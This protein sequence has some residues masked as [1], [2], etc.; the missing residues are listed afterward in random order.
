MKQRIDTAL[1]NDDIH[2]RWRTMHTLGLPKRFPQ[3]QNM[4]DSSVTTWITWVRDESNELIAAIDEEVTKR[5]DP[6][7]PFDGTASGIFLPLQHENEV[8]PQQQGVRQIDESDNRNSQKGESLEGRLVD[9]QS[10]GLQPNHHRKAE[11]SEGG[12]AFQSEVQQGSRDIDVV[13]MSTNR[14]EDLAKQNKGESHNELPTQTTM[15]RRIEESHTSSILQEQQAEDPFRTLRSFHEKQRGERQQNNTHHTSVTLHSTFEG[16]VGGVGVDHPK[17][18]RTTKK[19]QQHDQPQGTMPSQEI[20]HPRQ[21]N[22]LQ[23]PHNTTTY[24]NLPNSMQNKICGRCGSMGHIKR[25]CKEEV[26]CRYCKAYTHST[27]ACRTYPATS[28]RKNTPEKRTV[29]DIE[30][31]VSRRVQE[32]MKRIL[33]NL[34][35]SRR[36]TSTQQI[37]QT[38]QSSKRKDVTNQALGQHVQNLI[39]DFQRP[40]EVF[41]RVTGNSN[42]MEGIGDQILNQQWDEPPHMQPPMIPITASTSQAQY[43]ATNTTTRKVEMPAERQQAN[44]SNERLCYRAAVARE[45]AST[46]TTNRQVKTL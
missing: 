38:N 1:N 32:E 31:E 19:H 11:T 36:V 42:R 25:M 28:S 10:P 35:T 41:E 43:T 33:D 22:Y 46:F 7:D 12:A 4:K 44:L 14:Q 29:E 5:Q 24:M 23:G 45:K 40:P 13:D 3:P 37:L 18:Q 9:I 15:Q 2:R 39:G 8:P 6:D 27:T 21:D 30:R 20:N 16:A 17:P 34:S 26:Y